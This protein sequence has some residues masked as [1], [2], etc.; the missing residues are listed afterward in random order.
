MGEDMV[1]DL[2]PIYIANL[3]LSLIIVSGGLYAYLRS[4]SRIPLYIA[5]GFFLFGLTHLSSIMG[6]D[7]NF[8]LYNIVIRVI[9][10]LIIIFGLYLLWK[11]LRYS[12]KRAF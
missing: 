1:L 4:K 9:S 3:L 6:L 2:D 8:E 5:L 10:C 7:S 11:T 12:C